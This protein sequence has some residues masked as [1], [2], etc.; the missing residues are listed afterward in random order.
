MCGLRTIAELG[1]LE[2]SGPYKDGQIQTGSPE[3]GP[4]Y[5]IASKKQLV[6]SG[7]RCVR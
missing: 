2:F 7:E 3:F 1:D 6:F 4:V 5:Y